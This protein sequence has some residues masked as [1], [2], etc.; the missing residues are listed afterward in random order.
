MFCS[1]IVQ[2]ARRSMAVWHR[3]L[4]GAQTAA[5]DALLHPS[6]VAAL[7]ARADEA[8]RLERPLAALL[9]LATGFQFGG[10]SPTLCAT[11]SSNSIESAAGAAQSLSA[12]EP[13][14]ST[15]VP[16]VRVVITEAEDKDVQTAN[17][18]SASGLIVRQTP[19]SP[20]SSASG[21][22]AVRAALSASNA[23]TTTVATSSESTSDAARSPMSVARNS[24]ESGSALGAT[25]SR[26]APRRTA[27][28]R[29][30]LPLYRL[31]DDVI[32]KQ[33]AITAA[34]TYTA[35]PPAAENSPNE[36]DGKTATESATAS[37]QL[38]ER[39]HQQQQT[40]AQNGKQSI[41]ADAV[42]TSESAHSVSA[43]SS[44]ASSQVTGQTSTLLSPTCVGS[45]SA[46]AE[47]SPAE[48]ASDPI[49]M[50]ALARLS[51]A[52]ADNARD[53]A[54]LV[55]DVEQMGDLRGSSSQYSR[56]SVGVLVD[57]IHVQVRRL[58]TDLR[59]LYPHESF[60]EEET[61]KES[62]KSQENKPKVAPS[63]ALPQLAP[64]DSFEALLYS[65]LLYERER[66]SYRLRRIAR[67]CNSQ[68]TDELKTLDDLLKFADR[69]LSVPPS[70]AAERA[71]VEKR[72]EAAAQRS[73]K[74]TNKKPAKATKSNKSFTD[75]LYSLIK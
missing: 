72:L 62:A 34:K 75:L 35:E 60:D 3:D 71:D 39:T 48:V 8:A 73:P 23:P 38:N 16:L 74:T 46:V 21:V 53:L 49:R 42:G 65:S 24:P 52:F 26:A 22:Q 51:A 31:G 10:L 32:S 47:Q 54:E 50:R 28:A 36:T 69:V 41:S 59:I 58:Q 19:S 44:V 70:S 55:D 17:E 4:F 14:A 61:K 2:C 20:E 9:P 12:E 56:S 68:L 29:R 7:R 6:R 27:A 33:L 43:Q 25:V 30:P 5:R 45:L 63:K 40:A 18:R 1:R 57:S 37:I 15:G 13:A 11:G 67:R 66:C 64:T